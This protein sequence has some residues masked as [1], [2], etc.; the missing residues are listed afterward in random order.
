MN[1][2]ANCLYLYLTSHGLMSCIIDF[3]ACLWF[4]ICKILGVKYCAYSHF[5]AFDKGAKLFLIQYIFSRKILNYLF[6]SNTTINLSH[7][8]T[9]YLN[10]R[11]KIYKCG[12]QDRYCVT[13]IR[14]CDVTKR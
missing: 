6:K 14:E 5:C 13:K 4:L 8:C 10:L 3:L 7:L 2:S 9:N 11:F 12:H 1:K